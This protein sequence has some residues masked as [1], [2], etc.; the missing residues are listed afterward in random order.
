[1]QLNC[2]K[3]ISYRLREGGGTSSRERESEQEKLFILSD[4]N[5]GFKTLNPDIKTN[6][7]IKSN[8][9]PIIILKK[10]NLKII[11]PSQ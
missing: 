6:Q 9:I 5:L 4:I 1:M 3:I 10:K 7:T 2:V 11:L 8:Y